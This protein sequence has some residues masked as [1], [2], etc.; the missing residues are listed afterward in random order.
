MWNR[1]RLKRRIAHVHNVHS[2]FRGGKLWHDAP[3]YVRRG[4]YAVIA[5]CGADPWIP[6][7]Y[8][9]MDKYGIRIKF[10]ME[11]YFVNTPHY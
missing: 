10:S 3:M 2:F 6:F 11:G 5:L 7:E 9:Y 4:L 1:K 8:H